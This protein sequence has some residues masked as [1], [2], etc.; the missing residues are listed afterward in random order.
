MLCYNFQ[1]EPLFFRNECDMKGMQMS[2]QGAILQGEEEEG[3]H[4]NFTWCPHL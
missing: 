2:H 3:W 4:E 1:I